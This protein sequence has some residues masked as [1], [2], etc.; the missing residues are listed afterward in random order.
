LHAIVHDRYGPPDVLRRVDL[1]DPVPGPGA[2][3]IRTIAASLNPVDR[4]I[5]SG[6]LQGVFPVTFPAIPGRDGAGVVEAVGPG[7]PAELVGR[8]VTYVAPRGMGTW[9]GRITLD[10]K[11]VV[12]VPDA[13]STIDAAAIALAGVSAWEPLTAWTHVGPGTRILIHGAAGGV[14]GLA[15]QIAKARGAE[16]TGTCSARNVAHVRARGADTVVAYDET[17]FEGV[18]RGMDVVFD[19]I[20]GDVHDRSYAVLKPGGAMIGLLAAPIRDQGAAFGVSVKV[21]AVAPDAEKLAAVIAMAAA[22]TIR[23]DVGSTVPVDRFMEAVTAAEGPHARG[24]TVLTF[25]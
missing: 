6:M 16:V 10:A 1:P 14:G 25:G 15:V 18:V 8:R 5:R 23:A 20:G 11:F 13:L 9:A 12:P 22:G 7:G 4:K 2:V 24:K 3:S 19:L 21:T 17:P